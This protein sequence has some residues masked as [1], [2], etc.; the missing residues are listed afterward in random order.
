MNIDAETIVEPVAT[1]YE[2]SYPFDEAMSIEVFSYVNR[3]LW[4][5]LYN[6]S[7]VIEYR[8]DQVITIGDFQIER[9]QIIDKI[10]LTGKE[11]TQ[12]DSLM[13]RL[14]CESDD[15][16]FCYEPRH[17]FLFVNKE[18]ESFA[19]LEICFECISGIAT[20][21]FESPQLCD[22][23]NLKIMTFLQSKGINY[24]GE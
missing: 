7:Q 10:R 1:P 21:G 6:S 18:N 8:P 14:T 20:K 4:Q 3:G 2:T 12:L 22:N 15:V 11:I 17:F 13:Y 5:D 16:A 19:G 9:K 24:F 23:K